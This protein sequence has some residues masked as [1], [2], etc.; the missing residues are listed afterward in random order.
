MSS[1]TLGKM[2]CV[3]SVVCSLFVV[4]SL[5]GCTHVAA[6]DRAQLAH[7]TMSTADVSGPGEDHVR[8]VQE[9]A[10]GGSVSVGGGCGCN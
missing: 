10:I 4:A 2:K 9:G 5:A 1:P 6:Y 3:R 8:A 7:P